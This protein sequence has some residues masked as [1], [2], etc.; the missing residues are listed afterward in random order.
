MSSQ[1]QAKRHKVNLPIQ[2]VK[3]PFDA[4]RTAKSFRTIEQLLCP[5]DETHWMTAEG[6][7]RTQLQIPCIRSMVTYART[8]QYKNALKGLILFRGGLLYP[9][10][11][12]SFFREK[13]EMR[14]VNLKRLLLLVRDLRTEYSKKKATDGGYMV[15]SADSV[16]HTIRSLALMQHYSDVAN[17]KTPMLDVTKEL[18]VAA[19]FACPIPSP[20]APQSG[21][22]T[23]HVS[24]TRTHSQTRSMDRPRCVKVLLVPKPQALEDTGDGFWGDL[25]SGGQ[26][27]IQRLGDS[28][29]LLVELQ[30]LLPAS[31]LRPQNQ[32]GFVLVRERHIRAFH[33]LRQLICSGKH[34]TEVSRHTEFRYLTSEA[35]W[36]ARDFVVADF[37][38]PNEVSSSDFY[39]YNDMFP[40]VSHDRL[41]PDPDPL[42]NFLERLSRRHDTQETLPLWEDGEEPE[43]LEEW[44]V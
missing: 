33:T 3:N 7:Q 8:L 14:T 36:D 35:G 21:V 37:V 31:A 29:M 38:I 10:E 44:E 41:Y 34:I 42:K 19:S 23:S 28:D 13:T 18:R 17:V 40:A 11:K 4:T 39:C 9:T 32:S 1:P 20:L 12:S 2:T 16:V 5:D 15:S 22:L 26:W 6:P 25:R 43:W 27:L 24:Q 30:T